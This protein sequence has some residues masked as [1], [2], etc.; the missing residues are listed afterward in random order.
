MNLETA[1]PCR[2]I[3]GFLDAPLPAPS[4][5]WSAQNESTWKREYKHY[6]DQTGDGNFPTN[7]KLILMQA[8]NNYEAAWDDWF[9][10]IDGIGSLMVIATSML[11]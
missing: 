10:G 7:G 5:V 11:V 6:L 2:P 1:K 3:P 9:A 8:G 4:T